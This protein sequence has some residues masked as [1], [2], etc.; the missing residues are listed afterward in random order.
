MGKQEYLEQQLEYQKG[1]LEYS[2]ENGRGEEKVNYHL[3]K[4]DYIEGRLAEMKISPE[5]EA[6]V[7][8]FMERWREP[9]CT[10]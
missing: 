5:A 1:K 6:K 9:V 4:I 8:A 3:N 2:L 10:D 7:E